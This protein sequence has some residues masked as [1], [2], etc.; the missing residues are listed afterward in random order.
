MAA[1]AGPRHSLWKLFRVKIGN[2][3]T[4]S[5]GKTGLTQ[6]RFDLVTVGTGATA[7]T[8]ASKCRSAGW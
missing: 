4:S 2:Q 1:I 8:V 3:T 7:T 5:W 6:R